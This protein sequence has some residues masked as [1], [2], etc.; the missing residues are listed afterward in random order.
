M[1]YKVMG[2]DDYGYH[3]KGTAIF[4][5]DTWIPGITWTSLGQLLARK[6]TKSS[7]KIEMSF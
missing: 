7:A 1:Y 4:T 6:G 5:Y 3:S 2:F